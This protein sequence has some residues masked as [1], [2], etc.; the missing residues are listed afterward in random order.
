MVLPVDF[1]N[2]KDVSLVAETLQNIV[3]RG[4]PIRFGL[5]PK[6]DSTH[7]FAQARVVYGLIERHG[8]GAAMAYL[9]KVRLCLRPREERY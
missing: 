4:V 7:S 6:V 3:K 5:V 9:E 2:H 1:S 8:L